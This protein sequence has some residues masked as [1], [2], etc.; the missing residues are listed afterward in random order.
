MDIRFACQVC[1]AVLKVKAALSGKILQCPR[2]GKRTTVVPID[3]ASSQ[4]PS[5]APTTQTAVPSPAPLP[6]PPPPPAPVRPAPTPPAPPQPQRP[7]AAPQ[8][9]QP[10]GV[11]GVRPPAPE[12]P[13]I[14]EAAVSQEAAP[15][16]PKAV[17]LSEIEEKL[18]R[19][20]AELDVATLRA[21]KAEQEK[22]AALARLADDRERL[23]EETA[24]HYR[25][26]LE[27]AKKTISQLQAQIEE[28]K[29]RRVESLKS[30]RSAAEIERD[31]LK[32]GQ[33]ALTESEMA[34]ADAL[35]ADIKTSGMGRHVRLSVMIH[36]VVIILT[37]IFFIVSLVR[38]RSASPAPAT[39]PAASPQQSAPAPA[40]SA[41]AKT[42]NKV[43]H[44]T[45]KAPTPV[46]ATKPETGRR[47]P[48]TE[49]EKKVESL[50]SREELPKDTS[51]TLDLDR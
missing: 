42:E 36:A 29:R 49:L 22:E 48:K 19:L 4:S 17:D 28:E 46:S 12:A 25:A 40:A 47:E 11:S 18:R 23:R 35:I 43:E 24:A 45:E 13:A 51:V 31:L 44:G 38:G 9:Q 37:S 27:A 15:K 30:G 16:T 10:A 50:P 14:A 41:P 8:I 34:A 21:E 2:C 26:E 7:E 5:A 39:A 33:Y 3:E 6:Q 1:G 32:S 20:E